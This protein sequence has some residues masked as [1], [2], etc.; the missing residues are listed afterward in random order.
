MAS[1]T[2]QGRGRPPRAAPAEGSGGSAAHAHAWRVADRAGYG[3]TLR[4][5]TERAR[6]GRR[7]LRL[8]S[9]VWD[10]HPVRAGRPDA[11]ALFRR[12]IP[13]AVDGDRPPGASVKRPRWLR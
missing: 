2:P 9:I 1:G 10:A 6:L 12:A 5:G 3:P 11:A 13:P 4:K 8:G 7:G